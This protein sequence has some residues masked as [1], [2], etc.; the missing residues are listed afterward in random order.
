MISFDTTRF[1]RLEVNKDRVIQFPEGIIGF[2]DFK[3]C[4]LMDYKDTMLK[5]IQA[6]DDPDTAF[7]VVPTFE[8]FP[9]YSLKLEKNVKNLLAIENEDDITTL[10]I[11][12]VEGENVTANLQGPLVINS[13]NRKGAQVIIED[14]RFS[15]RTPLN[16]QP[17]STTAAK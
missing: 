6:V 10:V 12:R 7:I 4:I 8:F 11:V 2:P 5:W 3:R 14:Q 9:E 1:G 15:C 16:P 13:V 17:E